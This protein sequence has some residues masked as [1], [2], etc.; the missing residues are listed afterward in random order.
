M[1]RVL[2]AFVMLAVALPGILQAETVEEFRDEMGELVRPL[3]DSLQK[4][5]DKLAGHVETDQSV[6]PCEIV[7]AVDSPDSVELL[8][9]DTVLTFADSQ[10]IYVS[11]GEHGLR[12]RPRGHLPRKRNVYARR[13]SVVRVDVDLDRFRIDIVF[14]SFSI[15]RNLLSGD[16]ASTVFGYNP[17]AGVQFRRHYAGLDALVSG[18]WTGAA[19]DTTVDMSVL[20]NGVAA[21]YRFAFVQTYAVTLSVGAK[22]GVWTYE[23]THHGFRS[24]LYGGPVLAFDLGGRRA[25]FTSHLHL[26]LV[27]PISLQLPSIGFRLSF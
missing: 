7:L 16:T 11:E 24:R 5:N 6:Q 23:D 4:L 12:L 20:L 9:A 25:G 27:D 15:S 17:S 1:T 10:R 22:I 2:A 8:V 21:T 3:R 18:G 19:Y 26:L 14:L 13:D